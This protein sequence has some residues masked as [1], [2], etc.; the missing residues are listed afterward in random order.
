MKKL[1]LVVVLFFVSIFLSYAQSYNP[2][3]TDLGLYIQRMYED[4]PFEGARVVENVDY[5]YL[6]S[7]VAETPTANEYAT[8]R[9]AE[10]KALNYANTFLNGAHISQSSV[11]HSKKDSRGYTYEEIEE[12]IETQSMGHVQA[13]QLLTTFMINQGKKVYVYC[14]QLPIP[15]KSKGKK[16]KHKK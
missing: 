4:S 5:C 8:N 13:M 1:Y 11:M 10:V 2:E 3:L 15:D 6:V 9:K 14:K 12:F 7:V 16:S